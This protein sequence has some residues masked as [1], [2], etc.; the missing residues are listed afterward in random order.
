MWVYWVTLRSLPL[1]KYYLHVIL[2]EF[3]SWKI[4]FVVLIL[5]DPNQKICVTN[6]Y[7]QYSWLQNIKTTKLDHTMLFLFYIIYIWSFTLF[8]FKEKM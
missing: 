7:V 3:S 6:F 1:V 2:D 5:L 4:V 8:Y